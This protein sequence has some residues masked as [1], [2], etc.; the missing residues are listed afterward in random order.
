[1]SAEVRVDAAE[2]NLLV[3]VEG[4]GLAASAC[5]AADADPAEIDDVA[6]TLAQELRHSARLDGRRSA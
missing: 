2:G 5:L 4:D 6:E 1:V 3:G